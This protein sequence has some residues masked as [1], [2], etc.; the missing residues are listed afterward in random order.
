MAASAATR[1]RIARKI[2]LDFLEKENSLETT[3]LSV[4]LCPAFDCL[5]RSSGLQKE[6]AP[7]ASGDGP[8]RDGARSDRAAKRDTD[9]DFGRRPGAVDLAHH[10]RHFGFD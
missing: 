4:H 5:D 10:L 1:S 2:D 6:Q 9:G 7:A 3:E 8:V